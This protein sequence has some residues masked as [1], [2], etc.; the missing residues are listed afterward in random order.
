P[1]QGCVGDEAAIPIILAVDFGCGKTGRQRAAGNDVLGPDAMGRVVEIGEVT[2]SD[3]D[4][5]N[6]EP[7]VTGIDA[8]EIHQARERPLERGSVIVARLVDAAPG[9]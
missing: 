5:A 6:A 3:V 8:I 2:G 9:P 7:E 1:L 4:G